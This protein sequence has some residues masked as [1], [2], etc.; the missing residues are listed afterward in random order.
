MIELA[1]IY[2][3]RSSI[4]Q[5]KGDPLSS[6]VLIEILKDIAES[7][8][9]LATDIENLITEETPQAAIALALEVANLADQILQILAN[10]PP[11]SSI[12]SQLETALGSLTVLHE[13]V[14]SNDPGTTAEDIGASAGIGAATTAILGAYFRSAAF[15]SLLSKTL[16]TSA[17]LGGRVIPEAA[18]EYY[19][20]DSLPE[21]VKQALRAI[22]PANRPCIVGV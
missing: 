16:K 18:A 10:D 1:S 15:R 12:S 3:V 11:P 2:A 6:K 5:M 19:I 22:C 4:D 9:A 8:P 17:R 20:L 21:P 14:T 13:I 7:A